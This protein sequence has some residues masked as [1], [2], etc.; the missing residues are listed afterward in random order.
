[1]YG[2]SMCG[3]YKGKRRK[4]KEG[5]SKK[6]CDYEKHIPIVFLFTNNIVYV[7][8]KILSLY[9]QL[10]LIIIGGALIGPR[11]VLGAAHCERAATTFRVGAW[12]GISDGQEIDIDRLIV[13]PEYNDGGFDNDIILFHLAK[14]VVDVPYVKLGKETVTG[15]KLTVIGFGD[16]DPGPGLVLSST[17]RE[18][19]LD[20]VDNDT[21]DAGHGDRGDVSE[22]MLCAAG[23]DKDSCIGDSGGPLIVLGET[24][25]DD[26]LA[27]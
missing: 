8:L 6:K 18:V 15:G 10:R 12:D 3:K 5:R 27:G 13:H 19:E 24:V 4:R 26:I 9:F 20:Y 16:T 22:D 2:K 23:T 14:D 1:M 7:H 25:E 17:L 11:L 21:C